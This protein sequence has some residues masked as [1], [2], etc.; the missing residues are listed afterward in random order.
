[1]DFMSDSLMDGGKMRLLNVLEDFNGE[2]LGSDVAR[3]L[4][5]EPVT[6]TL[7]DLIDF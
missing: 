3:S 5:A 1:M 4:P 2:Y 7:D 6:R